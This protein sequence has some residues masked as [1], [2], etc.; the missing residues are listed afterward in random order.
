MKNT[1]RLNPRSMIIVS[2]ISGFPKK[3]MDF[4]KR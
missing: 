4:A 3:Q 2:I 1:N